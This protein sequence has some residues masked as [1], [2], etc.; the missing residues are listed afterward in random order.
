MS[1]KASGLHFDFEEPFLLLQTRLRKLNEKFQFDTLID[2]DTIRAEISE[3]LAL[4]SKL[5]DCLRMLS[6]RL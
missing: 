4:L 6:T 5:E 3:A 2:A 1:E